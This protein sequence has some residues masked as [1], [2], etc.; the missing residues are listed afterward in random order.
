M[1]G[2][3][4][5][6]EARH[7]SSGC[8][9]A[10]PICGSAKGS[11]ASVA[12]EAVSVVLFL[13]VDDFFGGGDSFK[14]NVVVVAVLEDHQAPADVFQ[15]QIESEIAVGHGGDGVNGIG[16]AA[17]DEIAKLLVDDIDFLAVVEF[18]GEV[19]HPFG[20]DVADA[21]KLFVT[22]GVGGFPFKNH[23]TAFEHGAFGD[24]YDGVAAGILAAVGDE[25][26]GEMLDIEFV[27]GDDA[28]IGGASHGG[29]HGGEAGVAAE[30]FEDHEAFMRTGGSAEAVDHLNGARN[31]GAEADAVGRARHIVFHGLGNAD[32][33]EAF[34]VQTDTIAQRVVTADGDE[35]INAKPSEILKD[36]RS[37]VVFFGGEFIFEMRGDGRLGHAARI[38]AG[39]M[40]KSAAGATRAVDDLFVE[41]EEIVGV[42]VV[43]L[44]D[45]IHETGPA[46]ANAD[47]LIALAQG[48]QSDAADGGVETRNVAAAGE[49]ADDAFLGVD[50][51]HDPRIALSLEAEEEIILFRGVFRKG[52]P[53]SCR[54]TI[55]IIE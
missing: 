3:T 49:D 53:D 50:V 4:A 32:H 43:L 44:A 48:A 42:V 22:I 34:L 17:A 35:S 36:F 18:G 9:A 52:R 19:S 1:A 2:R 47:D 6:E 37:E 54:G 27:F 21:T 26:L 46:M 12:E 25:E 11:N 29:K 51:S 28:T 13:D 16:I 24:Q 5:M 39:R 33:L 20:D 45:H 23:F 10:Q 40:Q 41:K 30:D 15:E 14:R 31:A 55:K 38:G 7:Q 8:C